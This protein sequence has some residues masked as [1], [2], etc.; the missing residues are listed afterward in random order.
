MLKTP[1]YETH[2]RLGARLVEF[3]GWEMPVMYRGINE[4]H[5]Y[6]RT[7]SSIFDVS[8]M[9]R[10]KFSGDDAERLLDRVC[11]RNIAKLV[12]GKSAYS[13]VCDERGG[14][15]DDVI[16][17]RFKDYL[18][19][20]CN[21]GNRD[22][23]MA[24]LRKHAEGLKVK[25]DDATTATVM[26]AIQG[27]ATLPMFKA[28]ADKWPIKVGEMPRY[29]FI[30][31][32]YMGMG[33]SV[34][35]SGYTG[36]DGLELVL[37]AS[38]GVLVW[39]FLTKDGGAD[40]VTVKPAG[41]GARDTLRLEAGMPLYGHELNENIDPISAGCKWCVDLTKEFIGAAALRDIDASGPARKI[42]GLELEGRRI[43][44]QG[45]KVFDGDREVGEV[46][47]GTLSPTLGKS[48]AMAYVDSALSTPGA[49][50]AIDVS[51]S[52]IAA[53]V[54]ALPFYKRPA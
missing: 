7:A 53:A 45:A 51:G 35:R 4:E 5:A 16:V 22:K 9:G 39:D 20:V 47:S 23:I 21:A 13:H 29:G 44:R 18:Y 30:A 50:L 6:T 1:L 26:L 40:R 36:E 37:P 25:I 8:H 19:M 3:G 41:L 33:Y 32:S 46:T 14:I 34:F 28:Q 15:L 27:P 31:G 17:S 52:R 49:Q 24:H 11:T 10:L 2:K 48:I 12:A 42:S 38:A 54:V 43:A